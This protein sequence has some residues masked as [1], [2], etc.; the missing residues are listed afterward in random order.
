MDSLKGFLSE[1]TCIVRKLLNSGHQS[2]SNAA[3]HY[4]DSYT[5]ICRSKRSPKPLL[6]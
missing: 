4:Y 1:S 2:Q 6:V 5:S 3:Y